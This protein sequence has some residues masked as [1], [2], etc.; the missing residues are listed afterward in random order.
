MGKAKLR[1]VDDTFDD[2]EEAHIEAAMD[3]LSTGAAK[4]LRSVVERIENL[5]KEETDLKADKK[6][7]YAEAK[8]SGYDVKILRKVISRRKQDKA[9]RGE[10]EAMIDLYESALDEL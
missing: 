10:E 8:A 1:V 4:G 6:E 5:E 3:V 7:V 2:S 9:K